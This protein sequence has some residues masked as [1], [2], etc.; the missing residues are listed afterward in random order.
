MGTRIRRPSRSSR[1]VRRTVLLVTNGGRT[2]KTYLE[3][4]R[5]RVPRDA[6]LAI[7]VIC[8]DGKEPGTILRNL[9]RGETDLG[10]YDET[11]IV[12]DHDGTDRRDF[13]VRCEKASKNS[14][15]GVAGVV[16]VP[17][18]EVWL[19][20]HYEQVQNYRDQKDAQ[21]HY[22]RLTGLS[23]RN[24]K[25]LPKDFPFDRAVEAACR[26]HLKGVPL[27][28]KNTQGPSPS[29]TMPHLLRSLGLLP[30]R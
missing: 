29:T 3:G 19:N 21:R 6:G 23:G 13:L 16:S 26:C 12:V 4:L 5:R 7:E 14:G 27:P 1:L 22:E 10:A 25:D 8:Q 9:V 20:A 30:A 17:C 2:E 18:F 15:G 24:A 28:E 11:W